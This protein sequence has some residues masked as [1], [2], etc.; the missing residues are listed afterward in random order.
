MAKEIK[1]TGYLNG[2]ELHGPIPPEAWA[3]MAKRLS[4][5]MSA[6]YSQ[7]PGEWAALC[8]ELDRKD[9]EKAAHAK[10]SSSA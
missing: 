3:V 10:E 1:V 6:Y 7:H 5:N 4:I 8:A 9:A 2:E